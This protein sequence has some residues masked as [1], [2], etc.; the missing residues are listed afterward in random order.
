MSPTSSPSTI[1]D[2]LMIN[3][4]HQPK[5]IMRHGA[6]TTIP[7]TPTTSSY[8][9]C[10]KSNCTH[11]TTAT[12]RT[13]S[14]V[15]DEQERA[16]PQYTVTRATVSRPLVRC[17]VNNLVYDK[18]NVQK[19]VTASNVS[20]NW[21]ERNTNPTTKTNAKYFRLPTSASAA[22]IGV[23]TKDFRP[24]ITNGRRRFSTLPTSS[25]M[26]IV[27]KKSP[28]PMTRLS[29][30]QVCLLKH[31]CDVGIFPSTT[32]DIY[33]VLETIASFASCQWY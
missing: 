9:S 6:N 24:L 4:Q 15:R 18:T 29:L 33:I 10:S 2:H 20:L 25:P 3:F 32:L 8:S 23:S 12:Q 5:L 11:S 27:K 19:P 31:E 16:K 13:S 30:E 1:Y 17:S 21:Q 14:L 22:N 26:I 7:S 28:S